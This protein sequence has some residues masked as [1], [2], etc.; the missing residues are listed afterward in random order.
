[1][2]NGWDGGQKGWRPEDGVPDLTVISNIDERGI[3]TNLKV[4]YEREQIYTYTG[5][6]LV[7][8]NPY[9][10][11][12]IYETDW[13]FK[14]NGQKISQ[15]E[16]H[17]FAIAEAAYSHLQLDG[18]NQACVI[19]GESGAG[20]TE[21]T[22]FILQYLCTVTSNQSTWMEHQILEANTILE[23]FGNA[24]TVRNDN[25]SRFGK[26][27]Q[28]CFDWRYQIKG[29]IIQD[30]LL[31]QS[32]ITFQSF[33]ERNYHVFY[34]LVTSAQ[35]NEDIRNQ[36]LIDPLDS[37]AYLRQSGCYKIDGVDDANMFDALRLAMS[38]LNIPPEMCD[39]IFSVLSAILWLGNLQFEDHLDGERC[40]LSPDDEMVIATVATL[41]GV[42]AFK[43]TLA[44]LQRQ[45]N[46]RGTV[47]DIPFKLHEARENRH[48]MAKALYS[49]TF[50]WIVAY[51]NTCTNPGQ[52]S[53]RFLGVLDI[54]GFEN[55]DVNSFEQLCINYANE[56]LHRFFNHYVFALEQEIYR[57]E[58]ISFS[59]IN[60]TDNTPCL[61]L[62]EK[63][64]KC[65]IRLLTEEC[66]IPKGTDTT[67]VNKLHSEFE[68]H[69]N[70]IR[71]DDRRRW[72]MEFGIKHYAGDV[73]YNITGFLEKNKD[74]Q[75]D[76]L[77]DLMHDSS[78]IFV[79]DL[80]K[81]QDLLS[82][83][84]SRVAN[85]TYASVG[86]A[87]GATKTSKGRPTVGDAFR[88]QLTALVDL[89]HSTNPWYVRCIKPNMVKAPNF[90]DERQVQTQLQYLGMLDII[91]IRR[92][93][94]PIH[95]AI[96]QFVLRYRCLVMKVVRLQGLQTDS[97]AKI[98]MT[99][100]MA[101]TEWQIG[102]NKVFLRS[103][104][105]EPLEEQRKALLNRM[106]VVIQKRMRGYFQRQAYIKLKSCVTIIQLHFKGHRERLRYL[107]MKRAAI[108]LQAFVRG[109]FAR[110]VAAAMKQMRRV[111]EE[112]RRK[113]VEDNER[114]QLDEQRRL[115]Q[116]QQNSDPLNDSQ[117]IN[118][119]GTEVNEPLLL[120]QQE[121]Q[122]IAKLIEQNGLLQRQ[123]I[124]PT[125]DPNHK[126]ESS[127]AD[128]EQM[129]SFLTE[130]QEAKADDVIADISQQFD[131]LIQKTETQ[132][133]ELNQQLSEMPVKKDTNANPEAA[134][135][136]SD[137]MSDT[138][139][140]VSPS[141]LGSPAATDRQSREADS[142]ISA[143]ESERSPL[144]TPLQTTE[145]SYSFE[146][147]NDDI[148]NQSFVDQNN[149]NNTKRTLSNGQQN[150]DQNMV[151]KKMNGWSPDSKPTV[152]VAPMPAIDGSP[153]PENKLLK[154]QLIE[155]QAD[156]NGVELR[157]YDLNEFADKFF[158]NHV[159]DFGGGGVMR[160]LTRKR[161]TGDDCVPKSEMFVWTAAT[162]IPTTHCHLHDPENVVIGCAI[163]KELC[164]YIEGNLKLEA[165]VRLIQTV[166]GHGIE[167]E[168][169]RDEIFVQ[170]VRQ[171]N[172]N[173]SRD[174]TIRV[175]MM[176]GL[177][178]AAFQP[179]KVFAKYFYSY[180]RKHLRKDASIS[181]YAQF[182]ID[183]LQSPKAHIRRMPPSA[184][185][186]NAVRTLSSLVCRFYFLDGRT[187]AIDIHPCDTANDAMA[188]LS[189]KIGLRCLDGW[190][191]YELTPEYERVIKGH[192]FIADI[193]TNWE[194]FQK[195]TTYG[196]TTGKPAAKQQAANL[197]LG[198][199]DCRFVF[200]KRLFKNTC[201]IPHDPVEVNLL[202]A[203]AVHSVVK[204]DEFPAS[205]RI[206]LQLAGLQAQVSLGEYVD[207]RIASY[208]DVEN[209]IC[210]R[211]RK[212]VG[213]TKM[214]WAMK[215]AD[216]HRMY[217][218][219]KADLI[220]KVWYLSVV[221]QYPTY[222]ATLFHVTYKGYLS[223]GHNLVLG[224]NSDGLLIT[225]PADKSILN[226]FRYCDIESLTVFPTENLLSIKLIKSLAENHKSF[227]FETNQKEE[228]AALVA[229]YSPNHSNWMRQ[230]NA[231]NGMAGANGEPNRRR[232]LKMTLEDRMKLHHDVVNCRRALIDSNIMRRPPDENRGLFRNT[233]RRLNKVR[234]DKMKH[235]FGSEFDEAFF[236]H[237]PHSFWAY[238]KCPTDHSI[239]VISDPELEAMAVNNFNAILAYSGL[240][241][242][243]TE[244]SALD[245]KEWPRQTER[246]Q[247]RLAQTILD[248]CLRKDADI[249][250]N[251][252]FLQ[253]IKQTTDHPDPNSRVNVRH[254]QLLA[255]ACSIT[256]PSDRRILAYLHSHLRRCALDEVT[257]EGQYSHFTLRNLQGT[258]E[259]RGR[260]LA[261]SRAE[262][263]STINCRR[264]YARIH[265]LDG[266]FQAV[267]FDA[268]AVISEVIEQIQLK[269][270]LRPNAPGF[271]L[272]QLLGVNNEQAL[273]PEEKVGD[274][275]AYWEKWHEEQAK[276]GT[277]T[278][279][280]HER[281]HF[282]VFK[283]HILLDA[284]VDMSDPVEKELLYHQ[285]VNNI[286]FDRFPIT[287]QEA[288]MLC[289]LKV[290]IDLGDYD[291]GVVDYRQ[292]IG[293]CL[294]PRLLN[295]IAPEA[296]V[297]QHQTLHSMQA[298]EAKQSF[299]N[300]IQSWP[301][302]RATIFE[303]MQTYT[304]SW[305]K[306]LWL[307][308]DQMGL[309]L[310][311]LKTRNVL[312]SCD[313]R[314][315]VDYNPTINS[316]MIVALATTGTKTMKYI[317]L[318][319]Q[320]LQIAQLIRDYT[321]VLAHERGIGR[322]KSVEFD[323]ALRPQ[324]MSGHHMIP[325][326]PQPR[327]TAQQRNGQPMSESLYQ[328]QQQR[329][330][331]QIQQHLYQQ[332]QQQNMRRSRPLSIL[333]KPPPQIIMTEA[334]HV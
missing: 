308:I 228:I 325:P 47:T 307:A 305:P 140:T 247:I 293:Q 168:E 60:F 292:A 67:Y 43:L 135:N 193:I 81:F 86:R 93:G 92:E 171:S 280:P 35:Y 282:F 183:N 236:R 273:Q 265:F 107:R 239:L 48:A 317:F 199:G 178:T 301:L 253:L 114:R 234:L 194:I 70:Y 225:N 248:K 189:S 122:T 324:Q 299:F 257:Q 283:K 102:K 310:L 115:A 133:N 127:Y 126:P 170:L 329:Q 73:V 19:S 58:G 294:P 64:P 245:E 263:L 210:F 223:Y 44:T 289:A 238:T 105:H 267:E 176:L 23:A 269:I 328:N 123:S 319:H 281:T 76:Q 1:M 227:T 270:D 296:V 266:Q 132:M 15:Q 37:Y 27:I 254:W 230:T 252:F 332:Q 159:R 250:R 111:E 326:I 334:E 113:E 100:K 99:L 272:Y 268:C 97:A 224:V 275:I 330:H 207:G 327:K 218:K 49:R 125:G 10:E 315:I 297:T 318:T 42:D 149:I 279:K 71:G 29:C 157:T 24:K 251:E 201:E 164:K 143:T 161:K 314:N 208:E 103:T 312:S 96:S 88:F 173:P 5:T 33:G 214:E 11:L 82:V 188:C 211:I 233:L 291:N 209:Y 72:G 119:N 242:P 303:V 118:A 101:K 16:P 154:Q 172:G 74:V 77:F 187:K 229:S 32:R 89:L 213:Y 204:K 25:S 220:A 94:F 120:A 148:E 163:F 20:K 137:M 66:R 83:T 53:D 78:N 304:S 243:E 45:I 18:A 246:D 311:E 117:Q 181:C 91:R 46:V 277:I 106:A 79:K 185:E 87:D 121:V 112:M 331:Q 144:Y 271:A 9:K 153:L 259:T 85:T 262:I 22:K 190:A 145:R 80:V 90:Y 21:S 179:S 57:Q 196:T 156:K 309:H 240:N 51:I 323:L 3:N 141:P 300:M 226:A 288:V 28:V 138:I 62:L 131:Q 169:L 244:E 287:E 39:G 290:Q 75:Q 212:A 12:D 124:D 249:L 166:I 182:C 260:K 61:E 205:E 128:L 30:Y 7:A 175:W 258:L 203:Q 302:H 322:R 158:N 6:I 150:D 241:I 26:F 177:T 50:A 142:M 313:Y 285:M 98:L 155:Q 136:G 130:I 4:R 59:H 104:V 109:M 192:D 65:V 221:M 284:F 191:L 167:R 13:V 36:F 256:Y 69:G 286:R 54:F 264:I 180:L 200:K 219:G 295:R 231:L 274:A 298:E 216:A 202:Y 276:T 222:G 316:L 146:F 56:K 116:M 134:A 184:L 232:L 55:F 261:P 321:S 152:P 147:N 255:L 186:V 151:D 95:F 63:P 14:Y 333:Y 68:S 38:V 84:A 217:G 40:K 129:F 206:A 8:V 17:V 2:D 197:T 165:E 34:Q 235:E 215:I 110:E 108:T 139:E 162:A 31:E 237:F 174:D 278:K 195:N 320:A 306:N 160:T 52:D 41:L 198:A